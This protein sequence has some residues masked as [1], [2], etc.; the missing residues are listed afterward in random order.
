[1][2]K[3]P[4]A[5]RIDDAVHPPSAAQ[6]LPQW[7]T[8]VTPRTVSWASRP[9]R[10]KGT[11]GG[12]ARWDVL[13]FIARATDHIPETGQQLIRNSGYYSNASRAKRR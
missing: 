9:K 8:V 6:R 7:V 4:P 13:E 11:S 5:I 1:M 12:I 2:L 3:Q 10:S